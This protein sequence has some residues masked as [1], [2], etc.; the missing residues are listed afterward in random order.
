MQACSSRFSSCSPRRGRIRISFAVRTAAFEIY[1]IIEQAKSIAP[2]IGEMGDRYRRI[3]KVDYFAARG[4]HE[5]VMLIHVAVIARGSGKMM[6]SPD[7]AQ[8]RQSLERPVHGGPRHAGNTIFHVRK[9]LLDGRVVSAFE[10]RSENHAALH[11]QRHSFT[12]AGRF[13]AFQMAFLVPLGVPHASV[14]QV[15]SANKWLLVNYCN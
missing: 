2:F 4:A 15:E 10:Q 14:K 7:K 5:M 1:R 12:P 6:G 11:R 9:N 13:E 3:R 8:A